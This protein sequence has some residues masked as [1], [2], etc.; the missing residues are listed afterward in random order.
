MSRKTQ[1]HNR[2]CLQFTDL[3]AGSMYEG[4][5]RHSQNLFATLLNLILLSSVFGTFSKVYDKV[6]SQLE[7]Y[8]L[9]NPYQTVWWTLITSC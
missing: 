9:Q 4:S 1:D 3:Q 7:S 2:Q 6:H 5:A 8:K